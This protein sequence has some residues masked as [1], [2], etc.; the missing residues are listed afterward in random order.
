[1]KPA[2]W[3]QRAYEGGV[4][5]AKQ[6][7]D[8]LAALRPASGRQRALEVPEDDVAGEVGLRR[9]RRTSVRRPRA[10]SGSSPSRCRP[11]RR[12]R[13]RPRG[14]SGLSAC[15]PPSA[16]ASARAASTGGHVRSRSRR[17]LRPAV[18]EQR[19]DERARGDDRAR[20][21][22]SGRS[23]SWEGVTCG[24]GSSSQYASCE[25]AASAAATYVIAAAVS[26]LRAPW[27]SPLETSPRSEI[28]AIA[29]RDASNSTG[30]VTS[31]KRTTTAKRM[32]ANVISPAIWAKSPIIRMKSQAWEANATAGHI[33]ERSRNGRV[34]LLV[35][36]RVA[37]L[38]RG[39]RRRRDRT[40]RVHGLREVH[41][42]LPRV[43]VV[44]ERAARR[45]LDGDAL[46]AVPV[47]DLPRHLGAREAVA[48]PDLHLRRHRLLQPVL[49]DEAD[50]HRRDE[51]REVEAPAAHLREAYRRRTIVTT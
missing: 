27:D 31:W 47:E 4:W 44:G 3:S 45:R 9:P 36:D 28:C 24:S 23:P 5:K 46:E 12:S 11:S 33:A 26:T 6:F 30:S 1:M 25:S 13:R 7:V 48:D 41:R 18:D 14:S 51:E 34:G 49:N 19:E 8:A 17:R 15:S 38:V 20:H 40:P 37:H 50:D 43:V 32:I 10:G 39:D 29:R 22:R 16:S 2:C 35:L 21:A 42:L